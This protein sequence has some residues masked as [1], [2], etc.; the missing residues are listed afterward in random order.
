[1][2]RDNDGEVSHKY[3]GNLTKQVYVDYARKKEN[4]KKQILK[5]WLTLSFPSVLPK[6]PAYDQ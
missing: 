5:R 4:K 3:G 6:Q 2:S 1:M